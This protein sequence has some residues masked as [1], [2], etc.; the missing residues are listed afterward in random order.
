MRKHEKKV[1]KSAL[2]E[3]LEKLERKDYNL[4]SE[5]GRSLLAEA[6]VEF[7]AKSKKRYS[8]R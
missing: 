3:A 1:L 7:L 5:A 2:S 8:W 6:V 4:E